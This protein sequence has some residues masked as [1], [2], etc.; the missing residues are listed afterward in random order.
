MPV[1]N[2][3]GLAHHFVDE[4]AGAPI[5]FLHGAT[6][7]HHQFTDSYTPAISQHFRCISTD[8]RGMGGSAHVET[9]PPTAWVDDQL[10][11]MD[12]LSIDEAHICGSSRGSRVALRFAIQHPD[13]VKSLILD[14]PIIAVSEAGNAALNS[15]AGDGSRLSP[16]RQAEMLRHHG[17]D[18]MDVVRNYFNIRNIPKLQKVLST[19]EEVD[20]IQCPVLLL[21][22]D[23]DDATHPLASTLELFARLPRARLLILPNMGYSV[24]RFGG[25]AFAQAVIDWVQQIESGKEIGNAFTSFDSCRSRL[26]NLAEA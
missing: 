23:S 19:R 15:N 20:Q 6:A 5:F 25:G 17:D 13:R 1:I 18:W 14:G 9:M 26:A 22:G 21:H 11:L 24:N 2:I 8:A 7:S 16:D 4:G 3:N 12:S 10:A